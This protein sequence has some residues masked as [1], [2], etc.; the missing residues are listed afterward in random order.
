MGKRKAYT[1]AEKLV[2]VQRV[3]NGESQAK[4]VR[5]TGVPESTLRGWLKEE[6]KLREFVVTVDESGGL[7]RKKARLAMDAELDSRLFNWFM[8]CRDAGIPMSG[9]ILLA[10]ASSGRG[11]RRCGLL[12]RKRMAPALERTAWDSSGQDLRGG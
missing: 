12:C 11:G 7:K 6:A 2:L 3:R 10:Q 9:P 8:Q 4:V 1:V 5:D